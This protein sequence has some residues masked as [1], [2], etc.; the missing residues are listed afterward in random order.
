MSGSSG[1]ARLLWNDDERRLRAPFRL[2]VTVSVLVVTV[3]V[4]GAGV[5]L[6]D[7]LFDPANPVVLAVVEIAFAAALTAG[8]RRRERGDRRRR[9][10]DGAVT[11]HWRTVR[12]RS[13]PV[14]VRRPRRGCRRTRP[15]GPS[16]DRLLRGPENN[17]ETDN[18][19]EGL[20]VSNPD[21]SPRTPPQTRDS[22]LSNPLSPRFVRRPYSKRHFGLKGQFGQPGRNGRTEGTAG[23][24]ATRGRDRRWS[25]A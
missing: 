9:P 12:P 17:I 23:D 2:G 20:I 14:R 16:P 21:I 13:R 15:V 3:P 4:L 10:A 7:R 6:L 8:Q 25:R 18:Y 24:G 11:R 19:H 1:L 22:I 5:L